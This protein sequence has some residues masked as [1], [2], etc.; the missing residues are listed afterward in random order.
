MSEIG[1]DTLPP[2]LENKFGS[3]AL[4]EIKNWKKK[5]SSELK[6]REKILAG[7]KT[8]E[9]K[10]TDRRRMGMEYRLE[11]P[12]QGT[13]QIFISPPIEYKPPPALRPY[14]IVEILRDLTKGQSIPPE[15]AQDEKRHRRVINLFQV[16]WPELAEIFYPLAVEK[17][18]EPV[19][20]SEVKLTGGRADFIGIGPDGRYIILE[21]GK[22]GKTPQ[23]EEYKQSLKNMGIPE[24]MIMT[25]KVSYSSAHQQTTLIITPVI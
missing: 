24:E 7:Y 21:I 25:F 17:A 13:W 1:S 18:V 2:F 16:N 9:M 12:H 8:K 11:T 23:I 14:R 10:K 3:E 15:V 20:F 4:E 22:G 5:H 19:G 6:K